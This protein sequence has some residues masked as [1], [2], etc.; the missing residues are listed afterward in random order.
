MRKLIAITLAAL[1]TPAC[2]TVAATGNG[3]EV[4]L[5]GESNIT[6][7]AAVAEANLRLRNSQAAGCYGI[8]VGG[9]AAAALER[10]MVYG[11]PFMV[12]CPAGVN[13][14][15]NGTRAP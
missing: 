4:I 9:Y 13:L 1:L 12:R 6:G 2:T 15:P 10:G 8:S 7:E 5:L 11:I 3:N 14:L